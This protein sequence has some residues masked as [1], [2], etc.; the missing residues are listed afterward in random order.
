MRVNMVATNKYSPSCNSNSF[1][2]VPSTFA[3]KSSMKLTFKTNSV[4]Q[5]EK[6][7]FKLI[8]LEA[9]PTAGLPFKLLRHPWNKTSK[10]ILW[11]E[12]TLL[13]SLGNSDA[14]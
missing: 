7:R 2:S 4:Y 3:P 9:V 1:A 8:T 14:T 10:E 11:T 6:I 5:V 13:K 12:C